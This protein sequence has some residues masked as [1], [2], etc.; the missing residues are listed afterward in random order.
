MLDNPIQKTLFHLT[1]LA[2]T[3]FP[4]GGAW[5]FDHTI[6]PI[7][8]NR[9]VVDTVFRKNLKTVKSVGEIKKILVVSDIHIGDAILAAGGVVAFRDFFPQA[10]IDFVVKKSVGCFFEGNPD[11]TNLYPVFTGGRYP[12]P[13]DQEFVRKLTHENKYDI[14]M[15]CCP[16]LEDREIF[17]KNQGVLNMMSMASQILRNLI[18]RKGSCHFMYMSYGL[19]YSVLSKIDK[20]KRDRP[21][22]G[23][24]L[25]L[26]DAAM[27]E[28]QALLREKKVPQAGPLFFLNPDAASPYN[29]IPFD[30]QVELLKRLLA[31]PGHVLLG[32]GFTAKDIEKQLLE[33]LSERER[34][35]VTV[36]PATVSLEG[37]AA[38]T[39]FADVF[40][41]ADTGPLHIAAARKVSKSGGF[42]FRNRTFVASIF[43]ATNARMS[44][45]DSKN[46]L[47]PPADQ[48][49]PSRV[50]VSESPCRN[51]TCMNK[52]AKTCKKVRCFEVLDVG[53]IASDIGQFLES[54][55]TPSVV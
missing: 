27:A 13:G 12:D 14:C 15:N 7:V 48:D 21:F 28:A 49:A 26:S 18:D 9:L 17:P 1:S 32:S 35:R 4:R 38:L 29:R 20:P 16:F 52:I 3:W 33:Q 53:A 25:T 37:Y 23:V 39:D 43:G 34:T 44:G 55:K 47:Y 54:L 10:Q 42:K 51:I 30:K 22:K 41:S 6:I 40:I 19:P 11:I 46:P 31:L 36:V 45:Y 8:G 2:T 24:P 5:F 50:Y